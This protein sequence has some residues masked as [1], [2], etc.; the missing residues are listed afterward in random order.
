MRVHISA[1]VEVFTGGRHHSCRLCMTPEND[2]ESSCTQTHKHTNTR[3][4]IQNDQ[5]HNLLQC[6]LRSHLVEIINWLVNCL[7]NRLL[8]HQQ[9]ALRLQLQFI[10]NRKKQ[11][12]P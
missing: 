12:V 11:N 4:D 2:D 1:N 8:E 6:S 9:L 3:T 7:V 10:L 5:S